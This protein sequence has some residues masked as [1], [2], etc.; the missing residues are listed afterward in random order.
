M[1]IIKFLPNYFLWHYTKAFRNIW[2][3]W[4]NFLWF[5]YNF[6]SLPILVRTLFLPWQ[7]LDE[8]YKKGFDVKEFSETLVVNS[9]M[10]IVGIFMR[11]TV[12]LVGS[13]A[14]VSV[15]FLGIGAFLLWVLLP[16]VIIFLLAEGTVALS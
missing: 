6:F 4:T 13:L 8:E 15:A 1:D 10:R 16:L 2:G 7:R 12:I 3:I 9:L 11:L 5:T 14:L